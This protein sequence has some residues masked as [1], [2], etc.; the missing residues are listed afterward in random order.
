M[1]AEAATLLL[2]E[3]AYDAVDAR[4]NAPGDRREQRGGARTL[5]TR[6]GEGLRDAQ[7]E[8]L[9]SASVRP[10]ARVRFACGGADRRISLQSWDATN[11]PPRS[12][13]VD[14]RAGMWTGAHT[15]RSLTVGVACGEPLGEDDT[16][17]L[18]VQRHADGAD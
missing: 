6:Q 7:L 16:G 2:L 9:A 13:A 17:L 5:E 10:V 11:V 8:C 4:A 1:P 12:G 14:A 3:C 18:I 15:V